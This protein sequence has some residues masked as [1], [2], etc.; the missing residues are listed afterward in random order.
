MSKGINHW[1]EPSL[2][3]SGIGIATIGEWVYFISFN[4]II[5]S[6]TGSA[7]AVTALYILKPLAS[8]FT[9]IWAG[10]LVD[11]VN[12]RKL[13]VTLDLLRAFLI[14]LLPWLSSLVLIYTVVFLINIASAI[15]SPTSMSYITK[16][17]PVER[18]KRFNSLYSLITSGAFLIGPA[19]AG[20]LFMVSTPIVTVYVNAVALFFSAL[21]TMLLP[22][23][24]DNTS[25]MNRLSFQ[26]VKNDWKEV[27]RFSHKS[28]Y[29][30]L[31]YT[32]FMSVMV[33]AASAVDSLEASFAKEVLSLTDSEY[34][35]LVS[36]AGGGIVGGALL[37]S[38]LV[39]KTKTSYLIGF[40]SLLVSTGY[41]MYAFSAS[42][43]I[44]AV[45]FFFLA[46]FIAFANTGFLTF[47]QHNIPTHLLGRVISFYQFV[48]S[49]LTMALTGLLGLLAELATIQIAVIT[50]VLV[51]FFLSNVLCVF[52]LWPSKKVHY[53]MDSL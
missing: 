27:I 16:L 35:F 51:M 52:S 20:L 47:Y 34:G 25:S 13:M 4:L 10:T 50:G 30:I 11:Q 24:D 5:F 18:R 39:Q 2:L 12:K 19:V 6:M 46:F 17:I 48:Q 22:D 42:L 41:L 9:N 53:E 36:I 45:G 49:I 23:V 43:L 40:G 21:I 38:L 32:L 15:F 1:K 26:M 33:V 7:M 44:A 14:A 3:L 29:V 28:P 37:N 31:I 8:L